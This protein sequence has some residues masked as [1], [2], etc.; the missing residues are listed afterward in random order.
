MQVHEIID[1][2]TL[3][4]VLDAVDD[5]LFADIHELEVGVFVLIAV[6]IDG[7]VDLLVHLDTITK[8]LGGFF[9]I[10][11]AI[12]GAGGLDISDVGHDEILVVALALHEENLDTVAGAGVDDPFPALLGR[13]GGIQDADD[14]ATSEP[15]QHVG[16]GG[17]GGSAALTLAL[18]VVHIKE[19]GSW[20][21]SIISTIVSNV[22]DL[23]RNRQ[24]L[25]V[26]LSY[27]DI[28]SVPTSE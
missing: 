6:T 25:K 28:R 8:V 7:L 13:V 26:A 10:L 17:L 4:V 27:D 16:N 9:W 5:D 11:A 23:R 18:G 1:N 12:V 19:V 21:W 15:S 3:E 14:A 24:P 2:S 20:L 22:E